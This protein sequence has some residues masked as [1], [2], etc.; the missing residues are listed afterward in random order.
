VESRKQNKTKTKLRDTEY[1][2]VVAR[3][4]EAGASTKRVMR[5]KYKLSVVKIK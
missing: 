5:V 4:E 3:R 2:S 1:R